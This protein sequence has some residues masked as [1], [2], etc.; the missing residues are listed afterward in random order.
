MVVEQSNSF[1]TNLF[2]G[3]YVFRRQSVR[4]PPRRMRIKNTQISINN[5]GVRS[6]FP[7]FLFHY[8]YSPLF[9]LILFY[10]ILF[11]S[12]LFHSIYFH[13]SLCIILP[14]YSNLFFSL[15]F[16]LLFIPITSYFFFLKKKLEL[17]ILKI[18][19]KK[20]KFLA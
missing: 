18:Y 3:V 9:L 10:F 17:I 15:P 8:I 13:S 20:K 12:F 4:I 6:F 11:S 1:S 2:L 5:P 19:S 16:Y 14:S 7:S